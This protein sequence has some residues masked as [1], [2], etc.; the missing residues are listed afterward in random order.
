MKESEGRGEEDPDQNS[1]PSDPFTFSLQRG[2]LRPASWG[3]FEKGKAAVF[4]AAAPR[5]ANCAACS[6]RRRPQRV[7]RRSRP[8]RS[9][10]SD[11]P[12]SE[13]QQGP[14]HRDCQNGAD[15]HETALRPGGGEGSHVQAVSYLFSPNTTCNLRRRGARGEPNKEL[16]TSWAGESILPRRRGRRWRFSHG[17]G[18]SVGT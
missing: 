12:A 16:R 13:R 17:F 8:H 18:D 2:G 15:R 6:A 11:R 3:S 10:P 1:G 7:S 5:E 4:L 14:P 9:V